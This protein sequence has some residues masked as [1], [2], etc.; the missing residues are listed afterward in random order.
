[1]LALHIPRVCCKAKPWVGLGNGHHQEK[2]VAQPRGGGMRSAYLGGAWHLWAPGTRSFPLLLSGNCQWPVA[3]TEGLQDTVGVHLDPVFICRPGCC[4]CRFPSSSLRN[5][6]L[7][8]G[9]LGGA[10][11]VSRVYFPRCWV[12]VWAKEWD[13]KTH[14]E[15]NPDFFVSGPLRH[16][17]QTWGDY[18]YDITVFPRAISICLPH[19]H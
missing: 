5:S 19:H 10:P 9:L 4:C 15:R 11:L 6:V 8:Q 18:C 16:R 13:M 17:D 14:T 2:M 3:H 12:E 1:M 7:S